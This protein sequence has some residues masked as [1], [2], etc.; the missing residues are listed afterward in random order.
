ML[1]TDG[2]IMASEH[3]ARHEQCRAVTGA[4]LIS[5][6]CDRCSTPVH[7]R[8]IV[9][10]GGLPIYWIDPGPVTSYDIGLEM[11]RAHSDFGSS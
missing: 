9:P 10:V 11:E 5:S 3:T 7:W 1:N 8:D 2:V 4:R 6:T